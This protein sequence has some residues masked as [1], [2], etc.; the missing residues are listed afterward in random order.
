MAKLTVNKIISLGVEAQ[1]S[2]DL[3]NANKYFTLVL[4][5]DPSHAEA[6]FRI[7]CIAKDSGKPNHA[8]RHFN[9][10]LRKDGSN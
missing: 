5:H 9:L 8:L 4:K 2:A 6:N 7:G 10:A 1:N 3:V